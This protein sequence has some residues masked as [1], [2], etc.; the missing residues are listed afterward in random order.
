VQSDTWALGKILASMAKAMKDGDK[1]EEKLLLLPI[2]QEFEQSLGYI[3]L[4]AIPI[5]FLSSSLR[6]VV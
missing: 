3:S 5:D 1:E 2:A 4:S 6:L